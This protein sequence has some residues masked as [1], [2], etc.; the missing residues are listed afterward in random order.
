MSAETRDP[1]PLTGAHCRVGG[2]LRGVNR[3]VAVSQICHASISI[4][5]RTEGYSHYHFIIYSGEALNLPIIM[6]QDE[7]VQLITHTCT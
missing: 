1:T 5:S 6:A 4:A 3:M 7:E 2:G